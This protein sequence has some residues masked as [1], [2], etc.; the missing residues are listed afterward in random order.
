[1]NGRSGKNLAA[2]VPDRPL[3]LARERGEDFQLLLTQYGLEQL[4]YRL[5]R[6]GY[7]DRFILKGTMLFMLWGEQPHRPTRDVDFLGFGD[8]DTASLR[9]IFRELCDIAIGNDDLTLMAESVQAET[10]RDAAGYGGIRVRLSGA[11]GPWH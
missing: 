1:M 8:S 9:K 5:S 10:I 4:L 6:S 2:P 11:G 7:Q 3:A